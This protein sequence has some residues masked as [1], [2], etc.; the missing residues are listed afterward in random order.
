[1]ERREDFL[2]HVGVREGQI[3][4]HLMTNPERQLAIKAWNNEYHASPPQVA[5]QGLPP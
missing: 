4:T 5:L 1:M 3:K 2:T